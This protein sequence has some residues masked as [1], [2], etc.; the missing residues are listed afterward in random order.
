MTMGLNILNSDSPFSQGLSTGIRLLLVEESSFVSEQDLVDALR[1]R[2]FG[3]DDAVAREA[4]RIAWAITW[5]HPLALGFFVFGLCA[6]HG[7]FDGHDSDDYVS[8]LLRVTPSNHA[9]EALALYSTYQA[10]EADG[11][12]AVIKGF[13]IESLQDFEEGVFGQA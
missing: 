3:A 11:G 12:A 2:V 13:G 6:S 1:T 8:R 10:N 9:R 5:L 4:A 7:W